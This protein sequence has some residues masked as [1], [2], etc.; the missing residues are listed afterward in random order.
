MGHL[1]GIDLMT[2]FPARPQEAS[3]AL[4]ES[5]DLP[6]DLL[7]ALD[8]SWDGMAFVDVNGRVLWKNRVLDAWTQETA[9]PQSWERLFVA[10]D[11]EGARLALRRMLAS[12]VERFEA[13]LNGSNRRR[14]L[15]TLTPLGVRGYRGALLLAHDP[16]RGAGGSEAEVARLRE[17]NESRSRF[18]NTAAHE[19]ST[20]LTSLRLQTHLL[21]HGNLGPL[22][23][24]QAAAAAILD[25]NMERLVNLV[26]NVLDVARLGADRLIVERRPADLTEIARHVVDSHEAAARERKVTLAIEAATAVPVHAD[27]DR[28]TQVFVNLIHNALK[29][30][31][32]GGRVDVRVSVAGDRVR[33]DVADTG[34]GVAP[35]DIP[36]LFLPFSQGRAGQEAE[37]AGSG[38]GLSICQGIVAQHDGRIWCESPGEGKGATF[39]FDLPLRTAGHTEPMGVALGGRRPAE[40]RSGWTLFYFRCPQCGSRDLEVR[41]LRN[42]YDCNA[43]GYVWR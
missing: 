19:F 3:H 37:A 18:I 9:S 31:R 20:P 32:A 23:E 16:G 27:P 7:A 34:V 26:G 41:L 10:A 36:Q 43:C 15:C 30:T 8:A 2:V 13:R 24:K 1:E 4:G 17:L 22:N 14:F 21:R 39:S 28:M 40:S 25:R 33:V 11:R 38:L 5:H 42:R 29:F 12:G 35:E 6:L